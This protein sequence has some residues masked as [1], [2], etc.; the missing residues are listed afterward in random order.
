MQR[1]MVIIMGLGESIVYIFMKFKRAE[2]DAVEDSW[3][4]YSI[5]Y[6]SEVKTNL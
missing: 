4:N 2:I 3:E 1:F 6:I 5:V